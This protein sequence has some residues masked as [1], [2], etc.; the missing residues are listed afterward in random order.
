[1][2]Q[3]TNPPSDATETRVP[4]KKIVQCLPTKHCQIL[5]LNTST[6]FS[7]FISSYV[8]FFSNLAV[9][10]NEIIKIARPR[11]IFLLT[12]CKCVSELYRSVPNR[13]MSLGTKVQKSVTRHA[14]SSSILTS[15]HLTFQMELINTIDSSIHTF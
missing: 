13:Q 8:I 5:S 15:H 6:F 14:F 3:R 12:V 7:K 9:S 4:V 1:M 11:N 2:F 10:N